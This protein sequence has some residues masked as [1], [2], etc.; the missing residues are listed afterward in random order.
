VTAP[1]MYLVTWDGDTYSHLADGSPI[2]F[3]EA[4]RWSYGVAGVTIRDS[5]GR[6]VFDDAGSLSRRAMGR[7][8]WRWREVR[9]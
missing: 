8:A 9:R 7:K 6:V 1:T 2:S 3:G 5:F 4:W